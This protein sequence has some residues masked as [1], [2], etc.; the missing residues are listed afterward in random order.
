MG[1]PYT[2]QA[3]PIVP[4]PGRAFALF[5]Q[6]FTSDDELHY[7]V[8]AAAKATAAPAAASTMVSIGRQAAWQ[9][10]GSG[11]RPSISGCLRGQG[12]LIRGFPI[13][14]EVLLE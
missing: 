2:A 7:G 8:D 5:S 13:V 4:P 6:T 9:V 1:L 3:V 10:S 12:G 14:D 11:P